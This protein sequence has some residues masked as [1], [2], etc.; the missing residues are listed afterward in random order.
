M[1]LLIEGELRRFVPIRNF[2]EEFGL[3]EAFGVAMFEPKDFSGLGRIDSAGTELNI[4]RRAVLDAVPSEMPLQEWLAYLPHLARLFESKLHEVNPEIGLKSVEVEYAVSG[5]QDVCQSLIYAMLR[6]RSAGEPM[7]E[8]NRV[9]VDW[10]N[11]SV[12]ISST[13]HSYIHKGESWAV[14]VVNNAYGRVGLIIWTEKDT[15]YVQDTGLACPAEGFIQTLLNEV[16]ARILVATDTT[17][18]AVS[19]T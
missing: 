6:A 13:V 7:P 5:F 19:G 2:R 17:P 11:S 8:F 4:V 16:A 15:H 18:P 12:R 1:H 3:P 9:Y 10:L 14:Q